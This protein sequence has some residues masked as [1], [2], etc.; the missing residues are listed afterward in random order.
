MSSGARLFIVIFLLFGLH[1]FLRLGL[2]LGSTTPDLLTLALL[3][4]ARDMRM[5]PAAL[6]GLTFGVLEDSFSA[7]AF[8]G[9]AVAMTIVGAAGA[10][11]RDL[12]VGD[13]MIFLVSYLF[14]GK[15]ARDLIQW[16]VVG[17]GVREPFVD[18][19]LV[20]AP[21][22]AG[23]LALVGLLTVATTGSWWETSQ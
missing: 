22:A 10:R 4:G 2:G 18:V 3:I 6:L 11:T 12:F 8:G 17:E 1:F 14:F 23:Y 13:S 9:S 20:Q 5:A 16:L 15:W 7:L 21:I 19:V